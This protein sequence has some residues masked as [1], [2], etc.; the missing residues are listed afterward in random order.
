MPTEWQYHA[1]GVKTAVRTA[2]DLD[3]TLT[4]VTVQL[5]SFR[6]RSWTEDMKEIEER[7]GR[8]ISSF[9]YDEVTDGYEEYGDGSHATLRFDV[10]AG[11]K[12]H[13][14]SIEPEDGDRVE[15]RHMML[16][17]AAERIVE[18]LSEVEIC[19]K[20]IETLENP[21]YDAK[22]AGIHIDRLDS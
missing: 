13:L 22:D 9:T 4:R 2:H 6:V 8:D 20:T 15:P 14:A 19:W 21:Y 12:A 11:R 18:Q 16:L 5:D 10:D 1:D 3:G 17:P 7:T